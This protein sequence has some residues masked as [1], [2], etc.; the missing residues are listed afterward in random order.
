MARLLSRR[1]LFTGLGGVAAF[2]AVTATQMGSAMAAPAGAT[3]QLVN[4]ALRIADTRSDG[5]GKVATGSSLHTVVPGLIG[6]GVV[7]ALINITITET[8][9]AGFLLA[10]ADNMASP[11]PRSNLNWYTTGQTVANLAVVPAAGTE[12]IG[13]TARGAGR[14]H[15]VLDLMGLFIGP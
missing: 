8:E 15:I 5:T 4:P 12:G 11:N 3:I 10:T 9:G 6:D 7:G 2:G 14:T 13:V 1:S